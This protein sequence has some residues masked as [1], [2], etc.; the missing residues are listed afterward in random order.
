LVVL[1]LRRSWQRVSSAVTKVVEEVVSVG[2]FESVRPRIQI[3]FPH[4]TVPT[5]ATAE[6][7][8]P[9]SARFYSAESFQQ[10]Q[11]ITA[12]YAVLRR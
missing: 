9:H 12:I 3:S 5:V 8:D 11:S 7:F 6:S 4:W 10:V 2:I 1:A